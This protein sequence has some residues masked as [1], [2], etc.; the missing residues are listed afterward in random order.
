MKRTS[1]LDDHTAKK[2]VQMPYQPRR[3]SWFVAVSRLH[4]E[5]GLPD[6]AER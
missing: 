5:F 1:D 2:I 4:L 3:P 6:M